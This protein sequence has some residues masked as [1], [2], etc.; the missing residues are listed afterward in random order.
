[1]GVDDAFSRSPSLSG[2]Y[3]TPLTA[4]NGKSSHLSNHSQGRSG[5]NSVRL[6]QNNKNVDLL[7]PS[8]ISPMSKLENSIEE[9]QNKTKDLKYIPEGLEKL[10]PPID[11][12][13]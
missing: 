11:L 8:D 7:K 6:G 2:A 9:M 12:L 4:Q 1:M 10:K 13:S 3:L 5:S